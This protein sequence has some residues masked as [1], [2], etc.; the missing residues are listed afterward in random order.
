[1][2]PRTHAAPA[3]RSAAILVALLAGALLLSGCSADE[4]GDAAD[5]STSASAGP[6]GREGAGAQEQRYPDVIAAEL[7]A[8]DGTY[9][10]A[11][12]IS[13]PYDSAER[14]ASGWRVIDPAGETLAEHRLAHDHADEQPFTRTQTGL[15]IPGNIEQVTIEGRDLTNGYGGGT[16]Q[17]DVP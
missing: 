11:V 3:R 8:D 14:Y 16:V 10:L 6:Q 12:T 2:R 13:S 15:E 17:L 4:Q 1:M 7:E 5:G 9:R